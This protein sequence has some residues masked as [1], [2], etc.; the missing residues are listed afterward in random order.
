VNV[1]AG[2]W[3]TRL[4]LR[5]LELRHAYAYRWAHKPLCDRFRRDVIRIGSVHLCRSCTAAYGGMVATALVYL[6]GPPVVRDVAPTIFPLLAMA[7]LVGSAPFWYK[8]WP[9]PMRDV[10]RSVMGATIAL[11]VCLVF[12]GHWLLGASGAAALLVFWRVYLALRRRRKR[13]ACNGCLELDR[14]AVCSG[15]AIHARGIRRYEEAATKL[16]ADQW[17]PADLPSGRTV[18]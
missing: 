8:R 18:D 17:S 12:A 2:T 5:W 1:H 3:R 9:R 10:L 15:Y 4:K 16:V 13:E 11:C 6:L 14:Q 7:A